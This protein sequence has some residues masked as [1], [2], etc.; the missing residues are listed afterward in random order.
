V[1]FAK[2][3]EVRWSDC[4]PNRHLRNSAFAD[5]ATHVRFTFLESRGFS[6]DEFAR[7][8][9]GPAVQHEETR[10]FREVLLGHRVTI[11]LTLAGLS[12]DGA[13]WRLRHSFTRGDGVLAARLTL[14]GGWI[15]LA[16][17]KLVV[18]PAQVTEAFRALDR[19]DDYEELR[20]L[21]DRPRAPE[22]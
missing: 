2:E 13:R 12:A 15:S 16:R 5:Y 21:D 6:V 3:L 20:S 8:D 9:V 18:P 11:D 1:R 7:L 17:R 4:D 19:D 14:A 22:Q 10:Y